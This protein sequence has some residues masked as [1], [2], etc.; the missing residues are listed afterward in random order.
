MDRY[1]LPEMVNIQSRFPEIILLCS[2]QRSVP[3]VINK[4]VNFLFQ[5]G[6]CSHEN[7]IFHTGP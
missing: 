1:I 2:G 4:A 3:Y 5:S 7:W 6:T